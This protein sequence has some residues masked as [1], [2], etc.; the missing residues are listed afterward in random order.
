M[1]PQWRPVVP[2]TLSTP[3]RIDK[4]RALRSQHMTE[5]T[6]AMDKRDEATK[7][8]YA[9]LNADQKKTFD[10]EHA[11]IGRHHGPHR[12]KAAEQSSAK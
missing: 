5:R 1:P 9:A 3:E 4:M 2:N 11:R 12:G 7:V 10:T 6:S 8:F